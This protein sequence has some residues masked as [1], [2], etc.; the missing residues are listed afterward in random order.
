MSAE[1]ACNAHVRVAEKTSAPFRRTRPGAEAFVLVRGHLPDGFK[2][3]TNRRWRGTVEQV[4]CGVGLD[5][6]DGDREGVGLVQPKL[7][8]C[9]QACVPLACRRGLGE[10]E[11]QRA[12]ECVGLL[13]NAGQGVTAGQ[14]PVQ[15]DGRRRFVSE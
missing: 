13:D 5:E 11:F 4:A 9:T 2:A 10:A 7:L 12:C 1:R 15:P 8:W 6:R 14:S 3:G